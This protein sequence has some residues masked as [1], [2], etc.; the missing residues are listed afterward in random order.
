MPMSVAMKTR[1]LAFSTLLV[2]F[3]RGRVPDMRRGHSRIRQSSMEGRS[4]LGTLERSAARH[5]TGPGAAAAPSAGLQSATALLRAAAG[6][7]I[8][9]DL[10]EAQSEI[11]GFLQEHRF[12]KQRSLLRMRL[13][14]D[15]SPGDPRR[16]FAMA[17][18][19][20]G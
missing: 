7:R 17:D 19:A 6:R 20:I 11:I 2:A 10:P 5:A 14:E 18:P 16:Q 15:P 13:G 8:F 9:W 12:E 1:V 4:S 3:L